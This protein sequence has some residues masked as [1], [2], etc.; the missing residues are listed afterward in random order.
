MKVS[1][2]AALTLGLSV[3]FAAPAIFA[4]DVIK[5]GVIQPL[6]GVGTDAGQRVHV[7]MKLAESEMNA[8]GAV[9][10]SMPAVQPGVLR[11]RFCVRTPLPGMPT[12]AARRV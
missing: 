7:A 11:Q 6:T 2:L 1:R 8:A 12:G 4:Q 9:E 5:I 3:L 10:L